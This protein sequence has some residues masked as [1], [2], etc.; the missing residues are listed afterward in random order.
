MIH[1]PKPAPRPGYEIRKTG[2]FPQY[3]A[4]LRLPPKSEVYSINLY[5]GIHVLHVQLANLNHHNY[6]YNNVGINVNSARNGNLITMSN[7]TNKKLLMLTETLI[8][9]RSLTWRKFYSQIH[10]G[11]P[12]KATSTPK[13]KRNVELGEP[14]RK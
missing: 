11:E 8:A 10:A 5:R 2:G 9:L 3:I 1:V 12:T 6:W 13:R 4:S 14:D 7:F